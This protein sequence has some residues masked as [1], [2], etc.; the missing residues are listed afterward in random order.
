MDATGLA[1][2]DIS[3]QVFTVNNCLHN[4]TVITFT[5]NIVGVFYVGARMGMCV[6]SIAPKQAGNPHFLL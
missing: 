4:N 1:N 2:D 3:K 5:V 6:P